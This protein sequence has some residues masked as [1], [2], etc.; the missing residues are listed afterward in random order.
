MTKAEALFW[1]HLKVRQKA[2]KH[3]FRPQQI[4]IGYI[5]DFYCEELRLAVEIDGRVH[6]RKDVKRNDAL[7]TR[8]LNRAGVTVLRFKNRNVFSEVHHLL[9][10]LEKVCR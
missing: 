2:W 6:E 1:R 9:S 10:L 8:R 7:R 3:Q 4:V 5:P